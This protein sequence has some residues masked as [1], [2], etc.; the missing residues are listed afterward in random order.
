VVLSARGIDGIARSIAIPVGLGC[1]LFQRRLDDRRW[2]SAAFGL[3]KAS[4]VSPHVDIRSAFES[5]TKTIWIR[6]GLPTCLWYI[7]VGGH[8]GKSTGTRADTGSTQGTRLCSTGSCRSGYLNAEIDRDKD[9]ECWSAILCRNETRRNADWTRPS[10]CNRSELDLYQ[11]YQKAFYEPVGAAGDEHQIH[12]RRNYRLSILG[13]CWL[14]DPHID[15]RLASWL[16]VTRHLSNMLE[17][18]APG[19]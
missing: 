12:H 15:C 2:I 11:Q 14:D 8:I 16:S 3:C 9:D 5:P 18:S 10:R 17:S 7:I 19:T 1:I 6:R 4:T 13:L